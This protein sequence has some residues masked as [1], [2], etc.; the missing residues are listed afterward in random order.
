MPAEPFQKVIFDRKCPFYVVIGGN[1]TNIFF[2]SPKLAR[3]DFLHQ[4]FA[5]LIKR[6]GTAALEQYSSANLFLTSFHTNFNS[7]KS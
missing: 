4:I 1:S 6:L 7:L 3:Q 5:R 2:P